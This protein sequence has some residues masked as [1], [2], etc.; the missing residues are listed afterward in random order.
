MATAGVRGRNTCSLPSTTMHTAGHPDVA[1]AAPVAAESPSRSDEAY[2]SLKTRLLL[3]EFPLNVRLGEERLAALLQ[4]SRTPVRE[5]LKRLFSEGLLER[6]PDGG[7]YQP[8]VPDV[9]VMR[10]LYEVRA[11]LELQA[12]QRPAR[13]GTRHDP[14]VLEPL[15]DQWRRLRAERPAPD[16][17]FVLLDESFHLQ[18]ARSAGNQVLVDLLRQVNERIRVV[19]MLDFLSE[20]RIEATIEEH[21]GIAELVLAGRDVDAEGAFSSHLAVSMAVVEERVQAA[22]ARMVSGARR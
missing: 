12:L 10:H 16:P 15:R 17:S 6:H 1:A 5:A 21:I 2:R 13:L 8:L 14:A 7:G 22:L 3:G 9:T 19:R 18:L 11:G 20:E 4:V